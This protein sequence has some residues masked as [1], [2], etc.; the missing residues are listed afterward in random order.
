[1]PLENISA[2]EEGRARQAAAQALNKIFRLAEE[3]D[4]LRTEGIP[5]IPAREAR[6]GPNGRE[7]PAT[8]EVPAVSPE[9]INEAFGANNT[10]ILDQIKA[11]VG[12][13][14]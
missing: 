6:T 3:I 14:E 9:A 12:V 2:T 10:V 7:F 13:E 1:M 4:Q 8:E 5:A 11:A